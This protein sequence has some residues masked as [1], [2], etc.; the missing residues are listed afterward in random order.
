MLDKL[1]MISDVHFEQTPERL[2][3]VLPIK[4]HWLY[5]ILY[6]VLMA[7]WMVMIVW[8]VIYAIQIMIS[9]ASYRFV[10]VAMILILLLVLI[11]FGRFLSRQWATYLSN[12]EVLFINSEELIVRRPVSI[13][14]NTD[15]YDMEHVTPFYVDD[16]QQALA[17]DY[18]YRHIYLG[19]GLTGDARQSLAKFLNETYFHERSEKKALTEKR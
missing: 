5:L 9:G 7:M 2:K 19:E 6:S 17:F 12:R 3:T 15:V 8:G 1:P 4:R 16:R 10:F 18:G 11:R 13:W 14:G